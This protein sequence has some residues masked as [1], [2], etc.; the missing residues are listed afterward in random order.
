M[1]IKSILLLI[2][3]T[4]ITAT[5]QNNAPMLSWN[6]SVKDV[7][8][9]GQLDRN[10]Q[11]FFC[12]A[13]KRIALISPK[14]DFAVILDQDNQTISTTLKEMFQIVPDHTR[15]TSDSGAPLQQVGSYAQLDTSTYLFVIDGRAIMFRSHSGAKGELSEQQLWET[16]PV[17]RYL[18]EG[19]Q[20]NAGAVSAIKAADKDARI[21]IALGT[22]CP[23]SRNYV[24]KLMKAL[25]AAGNNHIKVNIIGIDNQFH[26]PIDTI[27]Q[28][29]LVN[30]PTVIVE[31]DGREIGRIIETP[32]TESFEEDLAA[33]L[34][35][36]AITHNGR[37]DRG[38]RVARGIYA[39]KD[40][41]GKDIGR[42]EW[43]LFKTDEGGYLAHSR[44][45]EG[46]TKTEVWH[47]VNSA[48]RPTFIEV[49][50]QRG[51]ALIRTRYRLNDRTFTAR[52]RS[53]EAGV[54]DQTLNVAG[55][56]SVRSPSIVAEGWEFTIAAL[57]QKQSLSYFAPSAFDG[58]V[59]SL[60]KMNFEERPAETVN[61]PS[62]QFRAKHLVRYSG[63]ETSEWWL[64]SELGIPVRAKAAG[65][66]YVMTSIEISPRQ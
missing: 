35:G 14:L 66:E 43:E 50:K 15:A 48:T 28:L 10:A 52:M 45:T 42:E 2:A 63:G 34:A 31:R 33:I 39:Y 46:D 57:N 38:A 29:K 51:E 8:I 25:R 54:I 55:Y 41:A 27:Q 22:W 53:N 23:D 37:W 13:P 44:I 64:H 3:F 30:V 56:F 36:K 58:T 47:R 49:T 11:V 40:S 65:V 17:W 24:P 20:P 7:Y 12:D 9:D 26:D 6:E 1:R 62:G 21:T 32:A 16:V 18:M 60:T 59:G 5:A 4:V 19:Y 61:I